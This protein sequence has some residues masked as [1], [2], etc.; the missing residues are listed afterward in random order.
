MRY[1]KWFVLPSLLLVFCV[2]IVIATDLL[3]KN[4]K[5]YGKE[6]KNR[7]LESVVGNLP[8]V[9]VGESFQNPSNY[10]YFTGK[11]SF[12]LSSVNSRRTQF[13]IWQKELNYQG[14]PVFISRQNT[15]KSKDYHSNGYV[16]SGYFASN[17]QS[18]NRV[19]IDFSLTQDEVFSGD[20]L[21]IDFE[22][23]N[24]TSYDIHFDHAEFP[25]TCETVYLSYLKDKKGKIS[26]DFRFFHCEFER[27]IETLPAN[28]TIAGS[29]K[30]IVPDMNSDVYSFALTL[31]NTVCYA[32]NSNFI[33]LNISER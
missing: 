17:F 14:K 33:K 28:S 25:V 2:R 3:P 29:L 5:F 20:T 31:N 16:F 21:R 27:E 32:Q 12:V 18:V 13:D 7:A 15:D 6:D 1:V 30:A 11:E 22:M 10:S 24:P 9:F 4:L 23:C 26:K 19:K 8:V